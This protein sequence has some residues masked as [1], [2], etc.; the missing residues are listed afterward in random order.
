TCY[1]YEASTEHG[2]VHKRTATTRANGELVAGQST[3]EES[4]IAPDDTVVFERKS[5]WDGEQW[6]LLSTAVHEYDEQGRLIRTT[7]GNGRVSTASWM[8][9]GQLSETDEDGITTTYGYNS[10]L[11]LVETIRSEI[12]DGETLVTPETIVTY[13]RDAAGR[14]LQTRRDTGAMATVESIVYDQLGRPVVQTDLLGRVTTT[15]YS[16]DGLTTTVTTPAGATLVTE[17]HAD[18]SIMHEYG[19]GQRQLYH[20]YDLDGNCLRETVYLADRSTILS[21]TLTNG[22]GQIVAQV[23]PSTSGFIYDRSEYNAEGK[24]V[25]TGRDTG[26]GANA[27]SM[28]PTLYEYDAFGNLVKQTLAC[29]DEPSVLNSPVQEY[30]YGV[31]NTEDGVYTVTTQTR[32]NAEGQPLVS[33]QK[34]LVSELSSALES[35][36]VNIDERGLTSME[37]IEYAENTKKIQKSV[38]PSS[39]VTAQVVSIDGFVLSQTDYTGIAMM[40]NRSFTATGMT[41]TTTDGRGNTTTAQT[42]ITGRTVRLIDAAGHATTTEYDAASGQPSVVTDALGNTAC[43]RYDLFGRKVAEWG[44]AIQPALFAYDDA[45]RMVALTTYRTSAGDI[46]TDPADRTD[47]D[48]TTWAYHDATGLET[49]KTYADSSHVDKSYDAFNQLSTETNARGIVKTCTYDIK[50]GLLTGVSFSDDTPGQTIV[51]NHLGQITRLVDASGLRLMTYNVYGELESESVTMDSSTYRV[52]EHFDSCGRSMGYRLV[53]DVQDIQNT[54]IA[55]DDCGRIASLS[56]DG[57][58]APFTWSYA[59]GGGFVEGLD[60]PNGMSRKNTYDDKRNLVTVID[61]QRPNSV[62]SPAR[63]EY[64]FDKLGRPTQRKDT[65]NTAT[66]KTTRLFTYNSRSELI[67]DQLRPGG[68]FGYQY[69]NIG[70][71]KSAFEFGDTTD[72]TTNDLNQYAG[73]VKNGDKSFIPSYDEDGNQ[74]KVKTA[75]G[76][77][78]VSYNAENRPVKFENEN[79]ATTVECAYDYMG[80]RF[81]KKVVVN[82]ETTF[83]AR[84]LYRVYLQI[85]ELDLTQETPALVRSYIW[86]PSEPDSTRILMMTRWKTNGTEVDEHLYFMHDALKNVTSIFGEGRGRRALYEYRP[87]GGL[88]TSEGNMA[89][90]NKFRFSCEYMDDELGLIYYNYRHLNPFDGR[91]INR[92]PFLERGG[93]NLYGLVKNRPTNLYDELGFKLKEH[94]IGEYHVQKV[95]SISGGKNGATERKFAAQVKLP[96]TFLDFGNVA[97]SVQGDL[98]MTIKVVKSKSLDKDT[99]HELYHGSINLKYW[100]ML[101]KE[102]NY[103]EREW[104]KPCYRL[105][106]AYGTATISL[107]SQ[108]SVVENLEFD[109]NDY[110]RRKLKNIN[111]VRNQYKKEREKLKTNIKNYN[112]SVRE[113]YKKCLNGGNPSEQTMDFPEEPL[114]SDYQFPY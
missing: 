34:Q 78:N 57:A 66:P 73:I 35:K 13:T 20:V 114:K 39:S 42:D 49:S 83:H 101:A 45:S 11:Q 76:I 95:P 86:D 56:L 64:D 100:N 27:V 12:R 46:S 106:V 104:C 33:V 47:G 2:A 72:Y 102:I 29:D 79:G 32:Y 88:I 58:A 105:A 65:W 77:W 63:H 98:E 1:D 60:Y 112:D 91:W 22:F 84:F 31:E 10:A 54:Q 48:M 5:I 62:Y 15:A 99:K 28:A 103:L 8:C 38:I 55:Y 96:N 6:L 90:E 81:E 40:K 53:N 87:F 94:N 43:Y 52:S 18:G 16:E 51:Y 93:V 59:A 108:Q 71:R 30:A 25:R 3:K 23:T 107:R 21:Q 17:L 109:V 41:L 97:V 36:S 14:P 9:C 89:E 82:G 37:W 80:R 68:R 19:T 75:T 67:G 7:R 24:I 26:S 4:C 92:D 85:A 50:R 74:T 70:N 61:Y 111:G 44:T 69:D 113:F 110:T